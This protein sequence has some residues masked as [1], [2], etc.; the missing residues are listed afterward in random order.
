MS[1]CQSQEDMQL[2]SGGGDKSPM[3]TEYIIIV[4]VGGRNRYVEVL[5]G[6]VFLANMLSVLCWLC[7]RYFQK[8]FAELY[9]DGLW[10]CSVEENTRHDVSMRSMRLE[11]G[12]HSTHAC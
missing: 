9:G 4:S 5:G 7:R 2:Y 1:V 12:F 8:W 3:K 10:K 6:T 11:W